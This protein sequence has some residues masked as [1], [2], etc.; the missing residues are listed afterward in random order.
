MLDV[1][2]DQFTLIF[3]LED[4]SHWPHCANVC[5]DDVAQ[6]LNLTDIFGNKHR[7]N[8]KPRGYDVAFCWGETPFYFSF[9]YLEGSSHSGIILQFSAQ[10]WHFYQSKT[11]LNLYEVLQLLQDSRWQLRLSRCDIAADYINEGLTVGS[12]DESLKTEYVAAYAVR[13]NDLQRLNPKR[14][15]ISNDDVIQTLN[16]GVRSGNAYLRI[17]DKKAEQLAKRGADLERAQ[18]CNDWVRFE[19]EL[20]HDYAHAITK[21]FLKCQNADE[22]AHILAGALFSR[23]QFWEVAQKIRIELTPYSAMLAK[24]T[25]GYTLKNAFEVRDFS[26]LDSVAK[27]LKSSGFFGLCERLNACFGDNTHYEFMDYLARQYELNYTP[28]REHTRW[29]DYHAKEYSDNFNDW[30]DFEEREL[31]KIAL[32]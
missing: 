13:G 23:Y 25:G 30:N 10:A 4:D 19:L 14:N 6:K 5:V 18:T 21:D 9:A 3:L 7:T 24:E 8:T 28:S 27:F 11:G 15:T 12:I 26:L 17:Y 20:K 31:S 32:M 2:V 16:L 1:S 22:F 29:I